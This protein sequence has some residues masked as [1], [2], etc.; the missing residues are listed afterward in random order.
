MTVE[1]EYKSYPENKP[2]ESGRYLCLIYGLG[3]DNE[4]TV[5]SYSVKYDVFSA[6][7]GNNEEF[8]KLWSSNSRVIGFFDKNLNKVEKEIEV[9]K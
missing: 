2:S 6:T 4:F 5:W 9:E 3:D 7:D 8:A 1:L